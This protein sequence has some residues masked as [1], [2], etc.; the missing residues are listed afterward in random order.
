MLYG[1]YEFRCRFLSD[2][3]LPDYKGST[4]RGIFGHALKSLVCALRQQTCVT[5]LL[6]A[7]CLYAVVFETR[8]AVTPTAG[9]RIADV[10]H[11]FVIRPPLNDQTH[12][13]KGDIFVFSLLL[14]G[15]VNH[16]LPYFIYTVERMGNIGI[17]KKIDGRR[18][19]FTL[20]TISQENR[21]IY[22]HEDQTLLIDEDSPR[23]TLSDPPEVADSKSR[24]KIELKTPLRLKFKNQYVAELPFHILARA[25]LR[26]VSTLLTVYN[27]GEPPLDYHGLTKISETVQMTDSSLR[28]H[29]WHRYSNRQ[30]RKFSIR[31]LTGT[32]SYEGALKE[33]WP[34][35]EFCEKT[36]IGGKTAFGLGEIKVVK[37]T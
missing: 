18:A 13:E 28:P 32:V 17:G 3:H 35:I 8:L 33:F 16:Q 26:R 10:P 12:F 11:P 5:C 2:A 22:T 21:I 36:N 20:E 15:N 9:I 34:L 29:K 6:K 31:C 23:L 27:G 1:R 14:F 19:R 24:L 4:I 30:K 7:Q 37:V 25:M